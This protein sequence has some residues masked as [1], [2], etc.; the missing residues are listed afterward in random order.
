MGIYDQY[1]ELETPESVPDYT[2]LQFQCRLLTKNHLGTRSN[3][4]EYFG[5]YRN[6]VDLKMKLKELKALNYEIVSIRK[7]CITGV[8]WIEEDRVKTLIIAGI[9]LRNPVV[10]RVDY[11]DCIVYEGLNLTSEAW[12]LINI[13]E[14]LLSFIKFLTDEDF[15]KRNTESTAFIPV[16]FLAPRSES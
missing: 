12:K 10:K 2:R 6:W 14:K 15:R 5:L 13:D 16:R 1:E 11:I 9:G 8:K 4:L 7:H 3:P